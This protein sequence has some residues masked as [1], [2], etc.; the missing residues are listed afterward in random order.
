MIARVREIKTARPHARIILFGETITGWYLGGADT[1]SNRKYQDSIAET[2]PGPASDTLGALAKELGIYIAFGIARRTD[3]GLYNALVLMNPSGAVQAIHHKYL[4]V[5]SS[6]VPSLD[7]PYLNGDGATVTEID[8]VPF[9]LMVCND[10]HSQTI[11]Q[12]FTRHNVRVVLSA[13][14]DK[15][16]APEQDGWSPI[17]SIYNAWVVQANR[18]GTE[19]NET[20]P[21]ALSV[22]DP[23]GRVRASANRDG[24][25]AARIGVYR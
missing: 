17:S 20:Y 19:G 6:V 18:F 12:G 4:T 23:A 13:L 2:V 3:E 1:A 7:Y 10:M 24:W 16:D 21:G 14:S 22:I 11:A 8:G 9:G 15:S 5:H 25:I